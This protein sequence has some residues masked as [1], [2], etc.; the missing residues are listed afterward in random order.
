MLLK[1]II[2]ILRSPLVAAY[3]ST[4]REGGFRLKSTLACLEGGRVKEYDIPDYTIHPV[5]LDLSSCCRGIAIFIHRKMFNSNS[6]RT[7]L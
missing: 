7:R 5:N 4:G 3:A 1:F 6:T 2:F